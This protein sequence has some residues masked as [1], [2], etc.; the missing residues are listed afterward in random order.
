METN[1]GPLEG[2]R[3]EAEK[4]GDGEGGESK[5]REAGGGRRG[6]GGEVAE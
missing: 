2:G 6:G 5:V 1:D 3:D 4:G